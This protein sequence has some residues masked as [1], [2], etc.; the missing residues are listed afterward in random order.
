M[1]VKT[2]SSTVY[3]PF[4]A[5]NN[6][7]GVTLASGDTLNLLAT[8]SIFDFASGASYGISGAGSNSVVL[9]GNVFS[10]LAL[11]VFF[12][13]G[14]NDLNITG[15]STVSGGVNSDGVYF[16]GSNNNN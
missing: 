2:I 16:G 7:P 4:N 12:A 15:T 13:A 5:A 9:N 1:T 8:G 6:T 10:S 14:G 3:V 11:G